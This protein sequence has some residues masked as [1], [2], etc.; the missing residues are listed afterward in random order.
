MIKTYHERML[1]N[2]TVKGQQNPG[3]MIMNSN[4]SG[5]EQPIHLN[6]RYHQYKSIGI[7]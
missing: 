4:S 7:K 3:Q 2:N 6:Q 1:V 5:A